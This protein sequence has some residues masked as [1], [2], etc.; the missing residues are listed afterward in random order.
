[1]LLR[2]K[3]DSAINTKYIPG[4]AITNMEGAFHTFVTPLVS[5]LMHGDYKFSAQH[6]V[7]PLPPKD[8]EQCARIVMLSA[9]VQPDF[10][11]DEVF[12]QLAR[13]GQAPFVGAFLPH[14]FEL[15]DA[16]AKEDPETRKRYD[17]ALKRHLVANLTY[18]R[19]LP[20]ASGVSPLN[21]DVAESRLTNAIRRSTVV[22]AVSDAYVRLATGEILSLELLFRAALEQIRNEFRALERLCEN[23]YV[24]SFDPPAIFA[25]L[26]GATLL[27]RI[28][29]GAL[30]VFLGEVTLRHMRVYAF[31]DYADAG[32]LDLVQCALR[33]HAQII[34]MA[35][36][37]LFG[38]TGA[39]T[40]PLSCAGTILVLHNN[41][42]AFGQN[43]ETEGPRGSLDGAI[44]TYS[45]AA[46]SLHR[47]H[48][49][50]L[51]S[52]I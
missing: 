21:V 8:G 41:G 1:V 26:T 50:L 24:Y 6:G 16:E 4:S 15:L 12:V 5:I 20:S 11:N 46:A 10:E 43:I 31:N 45:S 23:G 33:T 44:G 27:N 51:D 19:I 36:A 13:L 28:H 40:P 34:V 17:L 25:R 42:D 18:K 29:I 14:D 48:P 2:N 47:Q 37:A 52:L 32:A 49:Q 38:E 7:Q 9:L 39:Y 22:Q 35:K 3:R 30:Q